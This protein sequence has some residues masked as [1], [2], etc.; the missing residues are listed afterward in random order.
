MYNSW[1]PDLLIDNHVTDG[2][3]HQYDL[4]VT[5]PTAPEVWPT[6]S[7]WS[8]EQL[9]PQLFADMERN[10]HVIGPYTNLLD[11]NDL[12]KGV[13]AM[14][15]TPRFSTGYAAVQNR[16][17]LL[18]E[19]HSLKSYRTQ[20]WAH[21]DAMLNCLAQ[22]AINPT[23]L[24]QAVREADQGVAK[25]A[26]SFGETPLYLAGTINQS[27]SKPFT[28]KAVAAKTQP[29]QIS[30]SN[31]LVYEPQPLDVPTQLF[32][33]IET[34]LTAAVPSAYLLPP[35][36][37]DIAE[38]LQLHGV[39]TMRLVKGISVFAESYQFSDVNWTPRSFEGRLRTNFKSRLITVNPSL[40]EG[41]YFVPL[42]NR[43]ARIAMQILEPGAPDSALRWG[44][45]NSIFEQKEYF[46]NY[47]MESI[48]ARMATENPK[49]QAEFAEKLRTDEKF[50]AD[51]QARLEFFYYRSPYAEAD[52]N[53]YPI[54]RLGSSPASFRLME[55]IIYLNNRLIKG[56]PLEEEFE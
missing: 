34:T 43:T 5:M 13:A 32:A 35:E 11:E 15:H 19:T 24:R 30:G 8:H 54:F 39:K 50:A 18:I 41:S 36:W 16:A 4:T 26:E 29:S 14:E 6:V 28:Y 55:V 23:V 22:V 17:G 49:L 31:Y 33:E 48:A 38:L 45:M 40:P 46:S 47:I 21:Y 56:L 7:R 3:D 27:V 52:R 20:V 53:I 25:L 37:S 42:N 2:L 51:P 12:K 1:L 44:F 10:G 9:L